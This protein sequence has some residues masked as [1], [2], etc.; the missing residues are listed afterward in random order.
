MGENSGIQWTDHT[1][2][3][4]VGCTKISPGCAHCYAEEYDRRV[5]RDPAGGDP[6]EWRED[7]RVREF[8]R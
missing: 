4:W 6:S 8:P 1:F 7:L 2:N 5:L 3:P